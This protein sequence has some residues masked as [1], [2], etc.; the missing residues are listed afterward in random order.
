M[1]LVGR[2]LLGDPT[3]PTFSCITRPISGQPADPTF[4]HAATDP[5]L[6]NSTDG[7]PTTGVTDSADF[8]ALF[9]DAHVLKAGGGLGERVG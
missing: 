2:F 9:P 7:Q 3:Y 1:F 6:D 8:K 5:I 4:S